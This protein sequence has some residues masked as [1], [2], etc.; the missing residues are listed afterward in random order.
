MDSTASAQGS[1]DPKGSM[2]EIAEKLIGERGLDAVSMR[3][4]ATAAGQRNNSA[5]QY[6]FGSRDGLVLQILR[7]RMDAINAQRAQFLAEADA[8]GLGGDLPTL[9][10][11]LLDPLVGLV[12][13]QPDAPHYARFLQRVGP[14]MAPGMPEADVRS[15]SD[16]IVVR[17][18]DA[19]PH[20]PRRVAFERVDLAV[21]MFTGALAVYEDRRDAGT[22]VLNTDFE[23]VVAH[24]Y[25]MIEASLRAG[26]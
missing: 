26:S 20:L 4:V 12:R 22:T 9:V 19:L 24:L 11:V 17:L 8:D 15:D 21:Q 16:G 10:R 5:V 25:A 6:H 3:D 1:K 18:M 14:V 2:I 7:R 13:D 23:T